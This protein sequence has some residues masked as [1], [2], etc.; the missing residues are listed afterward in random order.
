MKK[1]PFLRRPVRFVLYAALL[2]L[3]STAALIFGWQYK[4]DGMVLDHAMD[5]YGYL[6]TV[7]PTDGQILDSDADPDFEEN[8][9]MM[10]GP[11][12]VEEIPDDLVQWLYGRDDIAR[13]D[14]R[15]TRSGLLGEYDRINAKSNSVGQISK[16]GRSAEIQYYFLEGTVLTVHANADGE[17]AIDI[18]Q[19]RVDRMWSDPEY[20]AKQ[21]RVEIHR[22]GQESA[23]EPGQKVFLLGQYVYSGISGIAE[24]GETYVMTPGFHQTILGDDFT[25]NPVQK[26]AC[27]V[28]PDG[29]DPE[30]YIQELLASTGLDAMLERQRKTLYTVSLIETRDMTMIP[31]FAKGKALT[32]EGRGLTPKD[33]GEKVCVIPQA[34]ADRN[35]LSAGD[36]IALALGEGCYTDGTGRQTGLPGISDEFMEY[37]DY[38]VYEIVG[39]YSQKNIR[40]DNHLYF[41]YDDIFIPAEADTMAAVVQPYGFSLRI[42][43]PD[44][45]DFQ[46]DFQPVLDEY[47]YSMIVEDTGWDDVKESFYTMQ[48]R[49]KL[50][51]ACTCLAFGAAVA[52]FSVL[53]NA[54]CR[55]EYGLRRFLGAS[56]L[57]ALGI[58][59]GTFLFT[60]LPGGFVAAGVAWYAAVYFIKA[61]LFV[62]MP[63]PTDGECALC[64]AFWA[65]LELIAIAAALLILS[66]RNERRGLLRLVRR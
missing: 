64:L 27:T 5:T 16:A 29:A 59:G 4:L 37:G 10:G 43:G 55:Y 35:K 26:H 46:N 40:P 12:F 57:E 28:I 45:H 11:A 51:L 54:Y 32:Y 53:L 23:L 63:L 19:V 14:N 56:K 66:W 50:T 21:M 52:V 31:L 15:R 18:C 2:A 65:G 42:S 33:R 39:I 8:M 47:G 34:L 25:T 1:F 44:Y 20:P 62:E 3:I 60:A 58:Y 22:S 9:P 13:I 38:E 17:I 6:V 24:T 36:T 7:V 41:S 48:A 49:R 30:Q 61:A